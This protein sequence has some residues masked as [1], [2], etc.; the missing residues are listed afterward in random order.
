LFGLWNKDET[1]VY[2]GGDILKRCLKDIY[3]MMNKKGGEDEF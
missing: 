1:R 3:V 2:L